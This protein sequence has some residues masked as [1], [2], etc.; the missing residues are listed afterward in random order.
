MSSCPR[1]QVRRLALNFLAVEVT[2][3]ASIDGEDLFFGFA[4]SA[5]GP[6][7]G[8]GGLSRHGLIQ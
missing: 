3:D 1:L 7:T 5:R 8:D 6:E 2:A 4:A